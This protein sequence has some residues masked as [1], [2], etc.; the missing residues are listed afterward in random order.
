[1]KK[2]KVKCPLCM[3][4]MKLEG[5]V[6]VCPE[7]GYRLCDHKEDGD[8]IFNNED[9]THANY[10]TTS[11]YEDPYSYGEKPS[12]QG[13]YTD[14]AGRGSSSGTSLTTRPTTTQ[15]TFQTKTYREYKK[16]EQRNPVIKVVR[17]FFSI[18]FV[19]MFL[20]VIF[21]IVSKSSISN[22]IED[23]SDNITSVKFPTAAENDLIPA[24]LE[25]VFQ[26]SLDEIT[27]EELASI[28]RI[29]TLYDDYDN[30]YNVYF[31]SNTDMDILS[32]VRIENAYMNTA[33]LSL[34]SDI[35][36][37]CIPGIKLNP[38]DLDGMTQVS[39]LQCANSVDELLEIVPLPS[40]IQQLDLGKMASIGEF[41][42]PMV[43]L[44]MTSIGKFENLYGLYLDVDELKNP[45]A[46]GKLANLNFLQ[47]NCPDMADLDFL[48][49][50]ESL[51]QLHIFSE[52]MYD[53]SFLEN[54]PVL[55]V[56]WLEGGCYTTL[57]PLQNHSALRELYIY[58]NS[59]LADFSIIAT[60]PNLSSLELINLQ[61]SDLSFASRLTGLQNLGL[62]YCPVTDLSPLSS[63]PELQNVTVMGCDIQN[64]GG[65]SEDVLEI[66][67]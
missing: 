51:S 8:D 43:H 13:R 22:F 26:K 6:K 33:Q 66:Y 42:P 64:D 30:S 31:S 56:L 11:K 24:F 16:A 7:C 36:I 48:R 40:Q 5:D 12:A 52:K 4:K 34:L 23:L 37:L 18:Y 21:T 27:E 49:S 35:R 62:Y 61:I 32:P 28:Y 45:E 44:D 46:I 67:E 20:S 38:G 15:K 60:L 9:H 14:S 50:L 2:P 1:M 17:I 39:Y 25:E 10:V 41:D 47:I 3:T 59:E 55:S 63:L 19:M 53:I 65:L 57:S 29:E 58:D 54:M